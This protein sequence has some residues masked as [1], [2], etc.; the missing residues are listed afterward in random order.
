MPRRATDPEADGGGLAHTMSS[1]LEQQ[2][3]TDFE[4]DN[5]GGTKKAGTFPPGPPGSMPPRTFEAVEPMATPKEKDE[6]RLDS[7]SSG[8]ARLH[9]E[10]PQDGITDR[11]VGTEGGPRKRK[12]R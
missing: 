12:M 1:P 5:F 10:A 11:S 3:P 6:D 2:R 4:A 8:S 9:S 7:N